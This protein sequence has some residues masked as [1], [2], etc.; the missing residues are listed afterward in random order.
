[1][2]FLGVFAAVGAGWPVVSAVDDLHDEYVLMR[3]TVKVDHV[4]IACLW[5]IVYKQPCERDAR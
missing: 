2:A 1:M 3:H 5:A 4:D